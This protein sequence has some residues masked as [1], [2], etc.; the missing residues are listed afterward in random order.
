MDWVG[1][2]SAWVELLGKGKERLGVACKV[3]DVKDGSGV[4]DVIL[5]EVVI[6]SC[7][8]SPEEIASV[9]NMEVSPFPN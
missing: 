4:W 7:A 8:W 3:G 6:Q 5:L 2:I 9:L 1:H